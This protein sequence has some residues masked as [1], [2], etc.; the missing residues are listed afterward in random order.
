MFTIDHVAKCYISTHILLLFHVYTRGT[1]FSSK[2]LKKYKVETS[3]P[4]TLQKRIKKESH[5]K[6]LKT[7]YAIIKRTTIP[8]TNTVCCFSKAKY[9]KHFLLKNSVWRFINSCTSRTFG[10]RSIWPSTPILS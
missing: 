10:G 3:S 9:F 4:F 6:F 1:N 5:G 2:Y 8:N 7:C